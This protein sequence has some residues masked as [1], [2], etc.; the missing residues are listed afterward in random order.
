MTRRR[1]AAIRDP[2]RRAGFTL[3]EML[4]ALVILGFVLAAGTAAIAR[5][6]MTPTPRQVAERMQAAFLRARG[7]AIRTGGDAAVLV[8][9]PGR[10]FAYPADAAPSPLPDGMEIRLRAAA[11]LFAGGGRAH[12]VFR[13]D[14]SS[15]GADVLLTGGRP[16]AARIEVD[17]LTG[18][19]RLREVAAE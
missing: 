9:V 11:E 15:S 16:G 14:G 3:L 18:V 19:P 7:D 12:V 6:D 1:T 4:V 10:G 8:D 2:A 13:A 17:W 5:R